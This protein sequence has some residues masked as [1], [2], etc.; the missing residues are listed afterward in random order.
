MIWALSVRT[1]HFRCTLLFRFPIFYRCLD[2]PWAL[3]P[4][5]TPRLGGVRQKTGYVGVSAHRELL[6]SL[7][8]LRQKAGR[9]TRLALRGSRG[10]FRKN[11][12]KFKNFPPQF[13]CQIIQTKKNI[14][15]GKISRKKI[16]QKISS[17]WKAQICN[18]SFQ[19]HLRKKLGQFERGMSFSY[20][21]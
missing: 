20:R 6:I 5:V 7:V 8:F 18:L 16:A 12:E 14:F 10:T 2:V 19:L 9:T 17:L 21:E 4:A 3:Q 11:P 1:E 13:T 15:V